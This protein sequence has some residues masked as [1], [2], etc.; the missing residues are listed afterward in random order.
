MAYGLPTN[1][2]LNWDVKLNASIEAVKATADA[3]ETPAGA[4]TKADA[5]EAAAKAA[6]VPVTEKGAANGVATLGADSKVPSAQLPPISG[7]T[8]ADTTFTPAGNVAATDVQA[9]IQ[10]LDTEKETPAGA[11]AKVDTHAGATDPH[12]D[13]AYAD[14]VRVGGRYESSATADLVAGTV[15]KPTL[16]TT[17]GDDL[18]ASGALVIPSGG[19][20]VWALSASWLAQVP[21]S[22]PTR[23]FVDIAVNGA[24]SATSPLIWRSPLPKDEDRATITAA[25]SLAAGDTVEVTVYWDSGSPPKSY[26]VLNAYRVAR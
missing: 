4:Q 15:T 16:A 10:E 23:A 25:V 26:V 1:G 21:N 12:G 3:A 6:S 2:E 13:R 11:Q 22:T 18:I 14:A 19:G 8:A 7:G 24:S 17:A 20:G 5:A 9:A